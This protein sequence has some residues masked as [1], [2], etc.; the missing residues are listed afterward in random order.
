MLMSMISSDVV[1]TPQ[2]ATKYKKQ[3]NNSVIIFV[4]KHNFYYKFIVIIQTKLTLL[5]KIWFSECL[6]E[7]TKNLVFA[8]QR[9]S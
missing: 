5:G 6:K 9:T 4:N 1:F 2:A 7:T 3:K 8:F